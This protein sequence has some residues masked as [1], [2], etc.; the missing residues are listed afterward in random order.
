MCILRKIGSLQAVSVGYS[1]TGWLGT[2]LVRRYGRDSLCYVLVLLSLTWYFLFLRYVQDTPKSYQHDTN[3]RYLM[4]L[5][6]ISQYW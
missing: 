5:Y 6:R 1:L 4:K 2:E 3:V